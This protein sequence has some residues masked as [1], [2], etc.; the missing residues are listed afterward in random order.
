MISLRTARAR[1]RPLTLPGACTA[2]ARRSTLRQR[3]FHFIVHTLAWRDGGRRKPKLTIIGCGNASVGAGGC[4]SR[5]GLG[6][7][8]AFER[9]VRANYYN[10][11]CFIRTDEF[12]TCRVCTSCWQLHPRV[13]HAAGLQKPHATPCRG[14]GRFRQHCNHVGAARAALQRARSPMAGRLARA[15]GA[16]ARA[17]AAAAAAALG[18][19]PPGSCPVIGTSM[20]QPS[21]LPMLNKLHG[22]RTLAL[23]L[24]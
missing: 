24:P 19:R 10:R 14:L 17:A 8:R 7:S 21:P 4:I 22:R 18:A 15:Q 12:R 1:W 9:F 3:L 11:V 13:L 20:T 6:P 16:R 5:Q 23:H 2:A